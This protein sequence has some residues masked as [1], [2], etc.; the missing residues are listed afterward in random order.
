MAE[1]ITSSLRDA[2]FPSTRVKVIFLCLFFSCGFVKIVVHDNIL[3]GAED[4]LENTNYSTGWISAMINIPYMFTAVFMQFVHHRVKNVYQLW[5]GCLAIILGSVGVGFLPLTT[6]KIAAVC[7]TG[8][9]VACVEIAMMAL[10]VRYPDSA[11]HSFV[12]GDASGRLLTPIIY[13]GN[14]NKLF[15]PQASNSF[16]F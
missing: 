9:G 14:W 1:P 10:T 7:F 16:T 11:V 4:I 15:K 12:I 6:L 3:A 8:I 13:T 2:G 5:F